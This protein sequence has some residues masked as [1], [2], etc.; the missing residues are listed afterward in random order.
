MRHA[1]DNPSR[2]VH[3]VFDADDQDEVLALIDEA[4]RLSQD[5]A[6]RVQQQ[7]SGN[8]TV[9]TIDMRRRIGYVGGVRGEQRGHPPLTKLRLVLESKNVITAYP[10]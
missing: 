9:L 8:R 10:Y 3:G 1:E 6:N 4:Y 5:Q 7:R 2:P